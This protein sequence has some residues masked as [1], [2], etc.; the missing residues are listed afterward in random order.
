VLSD[1]SRVSL[2]HLVADR[3]TLCCFQICYDT[4]VLFGALPAI[5]ILW[6]SQEASLL[7][8]VDRACGLFTPEEI[9]LLEWADDLQMHHLKGYGET[10]NYRM[11]VPLLEDVVQSMDRA[12][13][14][15]KGLLLFFTKEMFLKGF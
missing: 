4:M 13:A 12:I 9:E 8:I 3:Q 7:E 15:L 14:T 6:S 5:D 11:G 10:L 1:R 2:L